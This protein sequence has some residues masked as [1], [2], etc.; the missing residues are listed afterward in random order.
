MVGTGTA[1]FDGFNWSTIPAP[2]QRSEILYSVA[3]FS[4]GGVRAVGQSGAIYLWNG[5][6]WANEPSGITSGLTGIANANG[7]PIA[8]GGGVILRRDNSGWV[9]EST[10]V[11]QTLKTVSYSGGETWAAGSNW[12]LRRQGLNQWQRLPDCPLES[13][14]S[15]WAASPSDVWVGGSDAKGAALAHFDGTSWRT[16]WLS[17]SVSS[18]ST[19]HG[20]WGRRSS[21]IYA[22]GNM[23]RSDGKHSETV[24]LRYNGVAWTPMS[25]RMVP[26]EFVSNRTLTGIYGYLDRFWVAGDDDYLKF[27]P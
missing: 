13:A 18:G 3:S 4:D 7:T 19:I 11:P 8:V 20:L 12:V 22:V 14:R 1:H 17:P 23:G 9:T 26:T 15:V 6:Q 16:A 25:T 24:L 2:L 10:F 27:I 5:T 21:E